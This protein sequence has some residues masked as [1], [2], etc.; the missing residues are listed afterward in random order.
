MFKL[1]IMDKRIHIQALIAIFAVGMVF[2]SCGDIDIVKRR[3]RPGYHVDVTKN[4]KKTKAAPETEVAD[5]RKAEKLKTI[6]SKKAK[7][8]VDKEDN[9]LAALADKGALNSRSIKRNNNS[10]KMDKVFQGLK[11]LDFKRQM[12]DAKKGIRPDKSA[13]TIDDWMSE[14]S[15][16]VAI[17]AVVSAIL[18]FLLGVGG[19]WVFFLP[20]IALFLAVSAIVFAILHKKQGGDSPKATIGLIFGI[21]IA[22]LAIIAL[23]VG[24]ILILLLFGL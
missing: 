13:G 4:N 7:V 23:V 18:F 9:S 15:L 24:L 11:G 10:E 1:T 12:R 17:G 16:G 3:Y 2:Q 14:L 21:M 6:E 5:S 19:T 22:G 20:L 8:V